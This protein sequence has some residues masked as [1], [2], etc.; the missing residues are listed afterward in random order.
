LSMCWRVLYQGSSGG[1]AFTSIPQHE[2]LEHFSFSWIHTRSW[3]SSC[4]IPGA[5]WF[6]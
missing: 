2:A 6:Q 1:E 3:R 4:G 5:G